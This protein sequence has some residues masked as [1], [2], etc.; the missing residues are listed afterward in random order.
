MEIPSTFNLHT[1][2]RPWLGGEPRAVA[3]NEEDKFLEWPSLANARLIAVAYQGGGMSALLDII[4]SKADVDCNSFQAMLE[5]LEELVTDQ[6]LIVFVQ[7]GVQ[8]LADAGPAVVHLMAGWEQ[9][10]RHS[11]GVSPMYLVLETGPRALTDAAFFPGGV[12]EW[13][14]NGK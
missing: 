11:S 9:Y 5:N 6:P 4:A 12:V 14:P 8:L 7:G 3:V 2:S 13:L 10:T 1:Y